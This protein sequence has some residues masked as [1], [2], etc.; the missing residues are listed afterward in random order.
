MV[1][2]EQLLNILPRDIQV[3]VQERKPRTSSEEGRL[4]DDYLQARKPVTFPSEGGLGRDRK[5]HHCREIGYIQKN[6]PKTQLVM[7]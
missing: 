3:W 6:C 7:W 4:A 2:T 5:R 1:V